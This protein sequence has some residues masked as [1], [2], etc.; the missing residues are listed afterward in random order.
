MFNKS[1]AYAY[2]NDSKKKSFHFFSFDCLF[3]FQTF[4][5]GI[6]VCKYFRLESKKEHE[7]RE[8]LFFIFL[9]FYFDIGSNMPVNKSGKRIEKCKLQRA[10]NVIIWAIQ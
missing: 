2:S 1:I 8:K 9:F 3:S 6:D 7:R 4:P 5:F 10:A